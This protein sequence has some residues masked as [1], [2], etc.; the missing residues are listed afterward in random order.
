MPEGAW[1]DADSPHVFFVLLPSSFY[2]S[3]HTIPP[4]LD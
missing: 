3:I 1:A 2:S 4:A